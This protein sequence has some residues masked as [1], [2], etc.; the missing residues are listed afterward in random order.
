MQGRPLFTRVVK[1]VME[2]NQ[3]RIFVLAFRT[4]VLNCPNAVTL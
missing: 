4:V 1:N 2:G 3:Y